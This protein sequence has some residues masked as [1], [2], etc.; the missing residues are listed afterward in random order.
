MIKT[1]FE[2]LRQTEQDLQELKL[3]SASQQ[4]ENDCLKYLLE[5]SQR[6]D[7]EQAQIHSSIEH[8]TLE[9]E[10][11]RVRHELE[12]TEKKAIQL[13]QRFE[14]SDE[15]VQFHMEKL[16]LKCDILRK[17]VLACTQRLDE[18]ND[19][20]QI[21]LKNEKQILKNRN[22]QEDSNNQ[23]KIIQLE[24][25][26]LTLRERY[27]EMLE[28]ANTL[29]TELN[30]VRKQLH[31]KEK[32]E[33][34][35][36]TDFEQERQ[37]AGV[38]ENELKFLKV[39]YDDACGRINT[40]SQQLEHLQTAFEQASRRCEKLEEEKIKI[41]AESK[42]LAKNVANVTAKYKNK[43]HTIKS[44]LEQTERE[45]REI[46]NSSDQFQY[47]LERLKNEL[48]YNKETIFEKEKII[49]DIQY[50]NLEITM[51][52]QSVEERVSSESKRLSE[53]VFKNQLLE[54]ELDRVRRSQYSE[55]ISI[56]RI[57]TNN[58][59][60]SLNDSSKYIEELKSRIDEFEH[61]FI[62]EKTSKESLQ[63]QIKILEEENADL[64][65]I[66]NQMRKRTQDGRK[67]ERDRN[68]E[69][70]QLIARTELNARQYMT[71]FNL[72]TLLPSSSFV[73]LVPLTSSTT[74]A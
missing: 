45:R 19:H 61:S 22:Q 3:K 6:T 51:E 73:K 44:R 17:H 7:I 2:Q 9:R 69:I 70:Q 38:L 33:T 58:L 39:K 54:E 68:I 29:K 35:V 71:N 67:E 64:R 66:M 47:E 21:E 37:R 16:K 27:N 42:S 20:I 48:I 30:N 40:G 72:T 32:F 18:Y 10:I 24:N 12:L 49:Q 41:D 15:T 31:E 59:D 52:K 65:D 55:N 1:T 4:E 34:N 74:I 11:D 26:L 5:K 36:N 13:E 56:R 46:Q 8:R 60:S 14:T 63:V 57:E 53:L 43:L 23:N 28:H 25:D 62:E 50:K